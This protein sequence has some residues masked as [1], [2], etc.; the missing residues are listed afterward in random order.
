MTQKEVIFSMK[1]FWCC[2]FMSFIFLCVYLLLFFIFL[3]HLQMGVSWLSMHINGHETNFQ[4]KY[5]AHKQMRFGH[6][7]DWYMQPSKIEL[8]I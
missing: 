1:V 2:L 6:M 5:Q 7:K 3:H 8:K 4:N